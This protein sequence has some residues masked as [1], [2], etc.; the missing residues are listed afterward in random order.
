MTNRISSYKGQAVFFLLASLLHFISSS[1]IFL[2]FAPSFFSFFFSYRPDMSVN[3]Q[4]DDGEI[5]SVSRKGA[6]LSVTVKDLL[7]DLGDGV[8][9]VPVKVKG[10]ILK[11]VAKW[12]E[13]AK[14]KITEEDQANVKDE[15]RKLPELDEWDNAFCDEL[16]DDAKVDMILAANLLD[17]KPLLDIVCISVA[18]LVKGQSPE[19]LRKVLERT[20]KPIPDDLSEGIPGIKK[21]EDKAATTEVG[22]PANKD[23]E[24][25]KRKR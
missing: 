19:E 16:D 22:E 8:T 23:A 12:M 25:S 7:E 14:D 21:A 3:L 24:A 18:S 9:S 5:I 4:A 15:D 20:N 13:Y 11:K 1:Y 10:P 17:I 2:A 6:V